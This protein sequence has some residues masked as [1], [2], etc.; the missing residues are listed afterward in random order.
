M[1]AKGWTHAI[2]NRRRGKEIVVESVLIDSIF[3]KVR[4]KKFN[5]GETVFE[6]KKRNQNQKCKRT[7]IFFA[8]KSGRRT[9]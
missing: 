3:F 5:R 1:R 9:R 7:H 4:G 2:R 8:S 6:E